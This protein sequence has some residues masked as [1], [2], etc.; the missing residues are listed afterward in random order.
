[1]QTIKNYL[2][3]FNV[4]DL[5]N[6][7]IEF[8][9]ILGY[10]SE[11][12][13]K[14][15]DSSVEDLLEMAQ[16]KVDGFN[17]DKALL[18]HWQNIDF[19]FQLTDEEMQDSM[20]LFK[21]DEIDTS[22]NQISSY[23]FFALKLSNETYNKT[24]LVNITR[25]INRL[26][27]MP[28]LILFQYGN[29]VTLAI[30]DRR[31]H[32]KDASKDVLEKVT[33]IKDIK[34]TQPHRAHLE[35]LKEIS[36]Q[37]LQVRNFNQLHKALSTILDIQTLNEKFYKDLTKWYYYA[38]KHIKL[39][40]TP[41]HY[42]SK[43]A[44]TKSFTVKLIAR[45][46]FSWFLKEKGLINKDL[47]ELYDYFDNR[48]PL[49]KNENERDF[50]DLNCYY[51]G[52]LQ[53]LFYNCL[54]TPLPK[55][56][57]RTSK[58]LINK[59]LPED[60]NFDMFEHI[61]FLNGGLFEKQDED[62]YNEIIEDDVLR[63]PNS[64]FYS[65]EITYKAGNKTIETQG[66][67]RILAHYK[68][69][70]SENTPL[71]EEVALDPELLGL[72]FENLLAELD[73]DE[74]VAKNARKEAGAY[75]T[76]RK[77]IDYMVN[78][79]LLLYLNKCADEE[80]K[81]EYKE[82]IKFMV[83]HEILND[84][85]EDF[86]S[87]VVK[88]LDKI[89]VLDPACG[90]GAFPM[91]MLHR[92]VSILKIV[93]HDNKKW[94]HLKMKSVDRQHQKKFED[95]ISIHMDDY[96][97]KL[98]IIRDSIY[99]IDIEPLAIQITKLRFFI[100]LIIDQNVDWSAP[101]KNYHIIPLPNLET[102]IICADSLQ[103]LEP[104][105]FVFGIEQELHEAKDKYF[106]PEV[107]IAKKEES[108]DQIAQ[109]LNEIY[110]DFHAKVFPKIKYNDVKSR[111]T[112][113]IEAFRKWFHFASFPAPFSNFHIFFPELEDKGFDIVIG[114]PP[115]GGSKISESIKTSLGLGSSDP[116]GAFLARFIDDQHSPLEHK[117]VLALIV[118]DTYM[119]IKSHFQLRQKIMR[120]HIHKIIRVH[121]DTFK[122]TVNTAISI[123]QFLKNNK[124]EYDTSHIC[125]MVD[126]TNISIHQNYN[127]YLDILYE[128]QEK[129]NDYQFSSPE[130]AIYHY[131]QDLIKT[132]SILPIFV[133]SSKLFS[134][135]NDKDSSFKEF[136]YNGKNTRIRIINQNNRDIEVIFFGKIGESHHGISTGN[137]F[138]HLYFSG[139]KGKNLKKLNKSN[140]LDLNDI[141]KFTEAEKLYGVD[142]DKYNGRYILPLDKGGASNTQTGW[143]PCY[144]VP[145]QYYIDWS[146]KSILQ[147]QKNAGF[148]WKNSDFFFRKG[149]TFSLTGVYAPT[150]RFNSHSVFEHNGSCLFSDFHDIN[151]LIA[152]LCSKFFKFLLKNYNNH[153]IVS[154]NFD[155]IPIPVD[156]NPKLI[157]LVKQIV[158]KQKQFPRYDYAS[159]EQ[160]EIDKL[161]YEMYGLNEEDIQEVENW[162]VR[163]YP[164]L[165]RK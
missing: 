86:E 30:I 106:D 95:I 96:S 72:V 100:S 23:L 89:K 19:L 28:A 102:K 85:D 105:Y 130:Y 101:E 142:P 71:E 145:T 41:D 92:I 21:A 120:S 40:H 153:T 47:L 69:T 52:V 5:Y 164:K 90:S 109:K 134:F 132:N 31:R 88:A 155:L 37:N 32:K 138:E 103:N 33:L 18:N 51:R 59:Y 1:M 35:I 74:A 58:E 110:P 79:S 133:S 159:N 83:Y 161:V 44:H 62:N 123:F 140:L 6:S 57:K 94:L 76:P 165:V 148:A 45:I 99:G 162:Y 114:N 49:L 78:E 111:E 151:F 137:N 3:K 27:L 75:Y 55:A 14:F 160:I 53:T 15:E 98:G 2:E 61:P 60:F 108:I 17:F 146:K 42:R 124:D 12:I 127:R 149:I 81:P 77:I 9:K 20:P 34:L 117:G 50:D 16:D 125:Q 82:Q 113:N 97:R 56:G 154:S 156:S 136:E 144:F 13:Q 73:P 147:M 38:V 24:D 48:K 135:M 143:L 10:E 11:R 25:Q 131:T 121:P 119:T 36:L 65:K 87:F 118:S 68:F 63:I 116:Y 22:K 107:S 126:L 4:D 115:Y 7:S 122:A 84:N 139:S 91:G 8:F 129:A 39:P 80:N 128:T 93:D 66:L 67:N 112:A 70:V 43:E 157:H 150:F 46:L 163:R 64:L 104:D 141:D 152:I 158:A 26:F 29:V 54:N